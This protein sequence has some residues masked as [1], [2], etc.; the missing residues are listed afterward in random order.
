MR[1]VCTF[2]NPSED[3]S[4]NLQFDINAT[5]TFDVVHELK[6]LCECADAY[7]WH[8]YIAGLRF[9]DEGN[10]AKQFRQWDTQQSEMRAAVTNRVERFLKRYP[11]GSETGLKDFP[12]AR[13]IVGCGTTIKLLRALDSYLFGTCRQSMSREWEQAIWRVGEEIDQRINQRR[14]EDDDDVTQC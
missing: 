1:V 6:I 14:H 12:D 4:Q 8:A 7:Y 10:T 3:A 2:A 11:H 5:D 13:Y 9:G